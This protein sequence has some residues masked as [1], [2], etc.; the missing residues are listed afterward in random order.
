MRK[1]VRE[2]VKTYTDRM[3]RIVP[4]THSVCTTTL[5]DKVFIIRNK[6]LE[7]YE[8]VEKKEVKMNAKKS[9]NNFD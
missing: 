8:L 9:K 3:F 1:I 5:R 7:V 6:H 2:Y 4:I